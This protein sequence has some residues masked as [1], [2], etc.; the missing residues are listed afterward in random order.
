MNGRPDQ[1]PLKRDG[2]GYADTRFEV[3]LDGHV[4]LTGSRYALGGAV[5]EEL[6]PWME[7]RVGVSMDVSCESNWP[8]GDVEQLVH[9]PRR[10]EQ[11]LAALEERGIRT[12]ADADSR[13]F[14]GHGH[15]CKEI[16][17]LRSGAPLGRMPD[18]V[19]W[20]GCHADV[21]A[22]VA[23]AVAYDVCIIPYGG[24]TTV[25]LAL[26]IP[27]EEER[28]VVSLDM[29]DM[30]RILD[31][32]K[33]SLMVTVEA[34]ITGQHLDEVL[35]SHQLCLGHEPDSCEFSSVGGWV[36]TRA[37][38]MKK[39]VYGN[40][41]ELVYGMKVV[42]P[43][44]TLTKGA[45]GPRTSL[46]PD[47][48]QMVFGSEGNIGVVSEVTLRVSPLPEKR[49]YGS[50]VFPDFATGINFMYEVARAKLWP[51]SVRLLDNEQFVFG[52]ALKPTDKSRWKVAMNDVQKFYVTK[53]KGFDVDKM[54]AAT[55][56]FEGRADTVKR[57]KSELSRLAA[58]YGA[59]DGGSENGERGYT[60]TF[61]IAYLRDIGFDYYFIA[62]S[63][64]TSMRWSAVHR[65]CEG[66]KAQIRSS[67]ERR[68][69]TRT[70]IS[71]RVTQLYDTGACVYFYFGFNFDGVEG[72]PVEI[73]EEVESEARDAILAFGGSL[74]HHHGIGKIRKKW[75]QGAVSET[76]VHMVRGLKNVVDP[77]N[78]FCANN[79]I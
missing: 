48:F 3:G 76:G 27:S 77:K 43:S 31:V 40:I 67:C 60:L 23:A 26:E 33:A 50:F 73:Y 71:C 2:W 42:T 16:F 21:D 63:F 74:S 44:G 9:P 12:A 64:E 14:H 20:P 24:G 54:C 39:N 10:N 6:R 57:Q 36:A 35:R 46:G 61:L 68:G 8:K 11:F 15:T 13:I 65:T 29:H 19:V 1:Q 62:E 41:E 34:G 52:R 59:I 55:C 45:D 7:D 4:R 22:I 70:F 78:I 69:I 47:V 32:D 38:G 51:A 72:D 37:S 58:M 5:L 30:C 75:Y 56:L 79:H 28:M 53:V 18:L 49:E 66:V 17:N 25:T